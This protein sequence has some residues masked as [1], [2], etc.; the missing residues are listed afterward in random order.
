MQSVIRP[1]HVVP[2]SLRLRGPL[3]FSALERA[4]N[5]IVQRHGALRAAFLPMPGVMPQERLER[6]RAFARTGLVPLGLHCQRIVDD[7]KAVVATVDMSESGSLDDG[8]ACGE[9]YDQALLAG[10][11]LAKPPLIRALLV[12]LGNGDHRLL[13]VCNHLICD[14]QSGHRIVE[15]LALLY[16]HYSGGGE[17]PFGSRPVGFQK[18]AV[19]QEENL[20]TGH[21]APAVRYW[22][23]QWARF[24]AGRIAP[25]DLPFALRAPNVPSFRA[26]SVRLPFR[27]EDANSVFAFG[28]YGDRLPNTET[29]P[30]SGG[31][32]C[33]R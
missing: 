7:A 8:P 27:P 19:W 13:I 24:A 4:L 29:P 26:E 28:G 31:G 1:P 10:F 16:Q 2:I 15:E 12:K 11:D 18:Y 21:Y 32:R 30:R 22:R 33:F 17:Y 14:A 3:E 9:I 23:D 6:L 25:T 5:E 20:K